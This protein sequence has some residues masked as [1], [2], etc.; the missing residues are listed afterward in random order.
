MIKWREVARRL[1]IS[2]LP[3]NL[4]SSYAAKD[5]PTIKIPSALFPPLRALNR[6]QLKEDQDE[7]KTT[8]SSFFPYVY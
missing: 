1:H 5:Y 4:P 3:R 6:V 8:C 7:Q 2:V